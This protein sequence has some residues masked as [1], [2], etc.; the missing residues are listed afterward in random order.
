MI[1]RATKG[2][3]RPAKRPE[4]PAAPDAPARPPMRGLGDAIARF[5]HAIGIK[6]CGPCRKRQDKLNALV[7]FSQ[8]QKKAARGNR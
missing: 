6:Q 1:I 2:S 8:A 3:V 7:P 4:K 5:T